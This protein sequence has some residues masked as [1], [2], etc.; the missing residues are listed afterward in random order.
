MNRKIEAFVKCIRQEVSYSHKNR[1]LH[2]LYPRFLP[3]PYPNISPSTPSSNNIIKLSLIEH[4]SSVFFSNILLSLC[5]LLNILSL[6]AF[7][8]CVF[9]FNGHTSKVSFHLLS[10]LPMVHDSEPC[11][12]RGNLPHVSL[13]NFSISG[14]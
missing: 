6:F 11:L 8:I 4:L 2:P 7:I 1:F 5:I 14:N 9:S 3:W 10:L 12:A 13:F